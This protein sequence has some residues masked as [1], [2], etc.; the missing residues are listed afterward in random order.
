MKLEGF[1]QPESTWEPESHLP[2]FVVNNC[3]PQDFERYRLKAVSQLFERTIQARL[4]SKNPKSVIHI[5]FDIYRYLFSE[6]PRLC[7]VKDFERLNLPENWYYI[8]NSDGTGR[9]I[10]FPVKLSIQ[11]D[12]RGKAT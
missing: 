3:T 1:H 4:Q 2:E 12:V 7:D 8:L 10:K 5:D 6:S 11:L 9:K